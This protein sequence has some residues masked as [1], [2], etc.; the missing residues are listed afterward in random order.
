MPHHPGA[1]AELQALLR[2]DFPLSA[3]LGAR[4]AVADGGQVILAAPLAPNRNRSGTAFA[5]SLNALATLA[6]WSWVWLRLRE[7]Q[8]VAEPV[9]QDSTIHYDRPVVT[10]FEATCD[11][12]PAAA[13]DRFLAA[14]RRRG[15]A[16]LRLGVLLADRDGPAASFTGRYV[17]TTPPRMAERR[18]VE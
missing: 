16:R 6:G 18:R 8:L 2:H 1:A 9:L 3:H 5:G 15:R 14:L 17:A 7:E 4:V 10:D 13:L 11:P 12:P